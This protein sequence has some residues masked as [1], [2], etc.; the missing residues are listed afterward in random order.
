MKN[1]PKVSISG[2]LLKWARKTRFGGDIEEASKKLKVTKEQ[3]ISWE[4][5][6]TNM[7]APEIRKLSKVYKRSETVFLLKTVP[8]SQEPP[9]FR[10]FLLEEAML[11][12]DTLMVMRKAQETQ[13]STIDLLGEIDN[14]LLNTLAPH[15]KDSD[16]LASKTIE[17]LK[18]NYELRFSSKNTKEQ[19]QQWKRLLESNN[20]MVLEYSFPL[21]DA[22]AFTIYNESIPVIILN[23]RDTD[24][25]RAFSLFHEFG[26]LLLQQSELDVEMTL[27]YT[28]S[29]ADELFCNQISA[30]ILVPSDLLK[31]KVLAGII[32]ESQVK[33]LAKKFKVSTSVIWRRLYDN[34]L[35][36]ESQYNK[37]LSKL[38]TFEP[39]KIEKS[40]KK[41]GANKNT[42]LYKK[43]RNMGELAIGATL[44]AFNSNRISHYE[45][46]SYLGIQSVALPRLQ[47]ILFT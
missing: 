24:N 30:N 26:H 40:K 11:S 20:V 29:I 25:G 35:I 32:D 45:V 18:I 46:L 17:A 33:D 42:H 22:R 31:Q 16:L 1:L 44:E 4:S 15:K 14:I 27:D 36:S 37:V 7:T 8:K 13:I 43:I 2:E 39:Y 3:I 23:S 5:Q 41:F 21:T 9:K 47:R 19:L 38:S 28:K 12:K 6:G 34:K 10:R